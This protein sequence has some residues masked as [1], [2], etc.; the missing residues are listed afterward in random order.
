MVAG[1]F[2]YLGYDM[3]RQM[4]CLPTRSSDQLGLPE[5]IL[6]RPMLLVIF[7]NVKDELLLAAP[8][9]RRQ[10]VDAKRAYEEGVVAQIGGC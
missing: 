2:G 10:G 5:A 4:E 6:L 9:R 7:D 8:V 3:V 1:L